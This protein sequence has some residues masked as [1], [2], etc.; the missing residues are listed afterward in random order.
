MKLLAFAIPF[1]VALALAPRAA[2]AGCPQAAEDG[3]NA[4]IKIEAVLEGA[5]ACARVDRV[6][7]ENGCVCHGTVTVVNDCT[8]DIVTTDFA[9]GSDDALLLPGET[10]FLDVEG[11]EPGVHHEELNLQGQGQ[12]FKLMLDYTVERRVL[13]TG[14]SVS[15]ADRPGLG[16]VGLGLAALLFA[17]RR[18]GR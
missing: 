7:P 16:A 18:R 12:L 2:H 15:G 9:F 8:Y 11:K 6:E 17:R 13:E 5:P 4:V 1:A 10:G 3:C 14:C